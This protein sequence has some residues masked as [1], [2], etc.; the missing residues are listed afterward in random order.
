MSRTKIDAGYDSLLEFDI[1]DITQPPLN[2][3]SPLQQLKPNEIIYDS[4]LLD[5]NGVPKDKID[6]DSTTKP[7]KRLSESH[8]DLTHP[9]NMTI[10]QIMEME[11]KKFT[12]IFI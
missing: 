4:S 12:Q 2:I 5:S 9:Q 10:E 8:L 1:D 3:S 6:H 7:I 11:A